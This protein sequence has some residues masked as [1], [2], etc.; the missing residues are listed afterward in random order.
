MK[1][2]PCRCRRPAHHDPHARQLEAPVSV[3][4]E[5]STRNVGTPRPS[6]TPARCTGSYVLTGQPVVH[7]HTRPHARRLDAPGGLRLPVGA[8]VNHITTFTRGRCTPPTRAPVRLPAPDAPPPVTPGRCMHRPE[9]N[10]DRQR[11]LSSGRPKREGWRRRPDLNRGWRF[12]RPL[13]YHLATAPS[14]PQRRRLGKTEDG[15]GNGIRTR[16][17]D[18]GKVALYH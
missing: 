5:M 17:F 2:Q 10:P 9:T 15:A 11:S 12:C 4:S 3:G 1:Q 14:E 16:D 18:H 13:P 6:R 8:A 7:A